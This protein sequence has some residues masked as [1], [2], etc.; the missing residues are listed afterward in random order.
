L[1]DD[2]FDLVKLQ[3]AVDTIVAN[4]KTQSTLQV[5]LSTFRAA[6]PQYTIEIDRE[7]TKAVQ[8]TM[9]QVFATLAGYLGSAYVDQF[10]KFGRTFQIY[11]QGDSRFRLRLEDIQQLTVRNQAGNM[12]PLGTL[13]NARPTVGASVISLYNLYPSATIIGVPA[14]GYS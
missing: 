6:V 12:I 5:V 13:M 2:S 1:R 3:N 8:L 14:M 10:N 11:V 4:A 9:D 7:K